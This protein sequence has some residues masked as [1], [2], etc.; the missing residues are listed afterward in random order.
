[1][2]DAKPS[3]KKQAAKSLDQQII[4][5]ENFIF[6][7]ENA[8]D[9]IVVGMGSGIIVYANDFAVK[10]FGYS[11]TEIIGNNM[12][13]FIPPQEY[14]RVRAIMMARLH[15]EVAPDRY[16]TALISKSKKK[17]LS[18]SPFPK[19]PGV[20]SRRHS[21]LFAMRSCTKKPRMP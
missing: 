17:Y 11:K 7:V 15:G 18:S 16:F 8:N 5:G 3:R 4:Y 19:Q 13:N 21:L 10:M 14:E 20:V 1:M 12:K 9:G 6:V 2:P